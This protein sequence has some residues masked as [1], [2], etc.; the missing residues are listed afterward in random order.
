MPGWYKDLTQRTPENPEINRIH[1]WTRD[2]SAA[3]NKRPHHDIINLWISGEKVGLGYEIDPKPYLWIDVSQEYQSND[4]AGAAHK[5]FAAINNLAQDP[6]YVQY[7]QGRQEEIR[8]DIDKY[9]QR[10][11]QNWSGD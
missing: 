5:V 10:G 4:V 8:G 2:L 1:D 6:K 9:Y 11:G 3:T 7:V